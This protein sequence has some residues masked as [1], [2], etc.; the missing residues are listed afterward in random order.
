MSETNNIFFYLEEKSDEVSKDNSDEIEK[1][2]FELENIEDDV[3]EPKLSLYFYKKK[4]IDEKF[5]INNTFFYEDYTIKELLKICNYYDIDKLVKASK[6]KKQDI[7]SSIV[8]FESLPENFEKVD[9]R[10]LMWSH[11]TDLMND[12]KMK[13]YIIW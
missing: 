3:E 9:R 10:H 1:M 8:Y 11:M 7:I 2:L 4:T 12:T 13:Q 6:C 5:G